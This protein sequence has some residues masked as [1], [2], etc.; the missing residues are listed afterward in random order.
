MLTKYSPRPYAY[1]KV[2]LYRGRVVSICPDPPPKCRGRR[3]TPEFQ[4]GM[5]PVD[6]ISTTTIYIKW[7]LIPSKRK[8]DGSI[9]E[10]IFH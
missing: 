6:S 3:Q 5:L 2:L 10:T 9:L 8:V 7:H 4:L 1:I